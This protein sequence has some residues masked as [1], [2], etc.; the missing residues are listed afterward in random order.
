MKTKTMIIGGVEVVVTIC[1]A[2]R[3]KVASS[4]QKAHHSGTRYDPA[5]MWIAKNLGKKLGS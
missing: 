2:S 4:I 5:A 3:R 1:P